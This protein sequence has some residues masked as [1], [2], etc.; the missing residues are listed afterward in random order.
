[1]AEDVSGQRRPN[2]SAQRGEPSLTLRDVL[3]RGDELSARRVHELVWRIGEALRQEADAA[4]GVC[5]CPR[6]EDVRIE[7]DARRRI[8]RPVRVSIARLRAARDTDRG[9]R[10]LSRWLGSVASRLATRSTL[11]DEIDK[12]P[13]PESLAQFTDV[14]HQ[15]SAFIRG[16]CREELT[17]AEAVTRLPALRPPVVSR[18]EIGVGAGVAA[19]CLVV[20]LA[21]IFLTRSRGAT[22][23]SVIEE[24]RLLTVAG[25]DGKVPLEEMLGRDGDEL[26]SRLRE[27]E[28][29]PLEKGEPYELLDKFTKLLPDA[30][31]KLTGWYSTVETASG[32]NWD[33]VKKLTVDVKEGWPAPVPG[34]DVTPDNQKESVRPMLK[35]W[36]WRDAARRAERAALPQDLDFEPWL[37]GVDE[38]SRRLLSMALPAEGVLGGTPAVE[39]IRRARS[40]DLIG[41]IETEAGTN[42]PGGGT[43]PPVWASEYGKR[44]QDIREV[45]ERIARSLPAW[46]PDRHSVLAGVPPIGERESAGLVGLVRALDTALTWAFSYPV[47]VPAAQ[48]RALLGGRVSN[49][50]GYADWLSGFGTS[51][52]RECQEWGRSQATRSEQAMRLVSPTTSGGGG[53]PESQP[54]WDQ[55]FGHEIARCDSVERELE[56]FA[57]ASLT[58]GVGQ[59]RALITERGDAAGAAALLGWLADRLE[60]RDVPMVCAGEEASILRASQALIPTVFDADSTMAEVPAI[61]HSTGDGRLEASAF[62]ELIERTA[63][64]K[65]KLLLGEALRIQGGPTGFA[66]ETKEL[67]RAWDAGVE[68]GSPDL[69]RVMSELG[70]EDLR[71]FAR[72]GSDMESR[73]FGYARA[74]AYAASLLGP[75]PVGAELT[76]TDLQSAHEAAKRYGK[77]EPRPRCLDDINLDGEQR[78]LVTAYVNARVTARAGQ[79]DL[80]E[81][82]ANLGGAMRTIES[83][84]WGQEPAQ[85]GAMDSRFLQTLVHPPAALDAELKSAAFVWSV[86]EFVVRGEDRPPDDAVKSCFDELRKWDVPGVPTPSPVEKIA[87]A[88]REGL[89]SDQLR[90]VPEQE[91]REY[92]QENGPASKG[93]TLVTTDPGQT[94][95]YYPYV[96]Y[97]PPGTKPGMA[98]AKIEFLLVTPGSAGDGAPKSIYMQVTEFSLRHL[99]AVIQSQPKLAAQVSSQLAGRREGKT[100]PFKLDS[101]IIGY[102]LGQAD[103]FVVAT[104]SWTGAMNDESIMD[105]DDLKTSGRW[106]ERVLQTVP[107]FDDNYW[108]SGWKLDVKYPSGP[109]R[110]TLDHPL[111]WVTLDGALMIAASAGCRLPTANE[112]ASAVGPPGGTCELGWLRRQRGAAGSGECDLPPNLAD[113]RWRGHMRGYAERLTSE[114][115]AQTGQIQN[116]DAVIRTDVGAHQFLSRDP[117]PDEGRITQYSLDLDD[118]FVWFRPVPPV[119]WGPTR[120]FHDLIGNVAELVYD[121]QQPLQANEKPKVD[122]W[123]IAGLSAVSPVP[124]EPDQLTAERLMVSRSVRVRDANVVQKIGGVS[125]YSDVGFRLAFDAKQQPDVVRLVKKMVS[126]ALATAHQP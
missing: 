118:Q 125:H 51:L 8:A 25:R 35:L 55:R 68:D 67:G 48:K 116:R 23:S 84:T 24:L 54:S 73:V 36:E 61:E 38:K 31:E 60:E 6:F 91:V 12:D 121:G 32:T 5:E 53:D 15:W 89:E 30:V 56:R 22:A 16:L 19:S 57:T 117:E 37:K 79:A 76:L 39:L 13:K 10:E 14:R 28:R 85:P 50:R 75:A 94:A 64:W 103:N 78:K 102:Q 104:P 80:T 113:K 7:C 97:Q 101:Q 4:G 59:A 2:D 112:W 77:L 107:Q 72:D 98:D 49:L 122:A 105:N 27:I 41:L 119:G 100:D 87:K 33:A 47:S 123:A 63:V 69:L 108:Q 111:T 120:R 44:L 126:E 45:L 71:R 95:P 115:N 83:V 110:P 18:R 66:L 88:L 70:A 106:F 43:D 124:F 3:V 65:E 114:R 34:R 86:L 74:V 82:C 58:T 21:L 42:Q 93:W 26:V 109:L 99:N 40:R 11:I 9:E 46:E 52:A 1:M 20:A 62:K 92:L 96:V 90:V 17:V 29:R 81:L